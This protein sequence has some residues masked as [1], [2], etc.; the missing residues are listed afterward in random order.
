MRHDL[1]HRQIP[2]DAPRRHSD[3]GGK[4]ARASPTVQTNV[5]QS[6]P[7]DLNR[8]SKYRV[9]RGTFVKNGGLYPHSFLNNYSHSIIATL[10]YMLYRVILLLLFQEVPCRANHFVIGRGD[11]KMR[12]LLPF[13]LIC[14][15][16]LATTPI[17]TKGSSRRWFSTGAH[18]VSDTAIGGCKPCALGGFLPA[19]YQ[20][21][22]AETFFLWDN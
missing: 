19:F 5:C 17:F 20:D 6:Q 21:R 10:K 11:Y 8:H 22:K 18:A 9:Y 14:D 3:R 12:F 13:H 4:P 2:A 7:L 1:P 15:Y 16:S